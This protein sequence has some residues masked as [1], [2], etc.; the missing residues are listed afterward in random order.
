MGPHI[1]PNTEHKSFTKCKK[2]LFFS[3][4]T[5]APLVNRYQ[6][7]ADSGATLKKYTKAIF[8]TRQH[9]NLKR[10]DVCR[11]VLTIIAPVSAY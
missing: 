8:T 7:L 10:L 6:K 4:L 11:T 5:H 1:H 3:F 2:N 9:C